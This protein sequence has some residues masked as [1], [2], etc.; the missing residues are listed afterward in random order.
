[1][2]VE[3][4]FGPPGTGKTH[5]LLDIM[6]RELKAGV[7]PTEIAYLTFTRH[8][9]Q[10]AIDRVKQDLDVGPEDLPFFRTLHAIAYRQLGVT[11]G[12]MVA[13][14][15]A[16]RP[17]A[18]RLGL[19]FTPDTVRAD[20]DLGTFTAGTTLGDRLVAFDHW[21]RHRLLGIKQSLMF[22]R[23]DDEPLVV[24]RF[25][26]SYEAWREA[27]SLFDFTDLLQRVTEPLPVKVAIVD[28]AQDLSDLQW[29]AF[30]VFAAQAERV[31]I[32]GDDDQAIFTWAGASPQTFLNLPCDHQRV[33]AQSYRVPMLVASVAHRIIERVKVRQPK[34]W[35][36]REEMGSL[37]YGMG[38]LLDV[39]LPT[40]GS[41]QVLYRNHYVGRD[42]EE[43]LKMAGVAYARNDKAA[44]GAQWGRA[45]VAWERLRKGIP[46]TAAEATAVLEAMSTKRRARGK[47]DLPPEVSLA[48][49]RDEQGIVQTHVQGPWFEALDRIQDDEAQ[50][51]RAVLRH[52]GP[53]G[54]L[55]EPR[56][57]LSTIHA[58][59]GSE[60]DHVYVLGDMSKRTYEAALTDPDTER[61]VLYVGVTRARRTLTL[62]N[63][64]ANPILQTLV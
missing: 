62:L 35:K 57:R 61:R 6:S 29:Q 27:E 4:I 11:Q 64:W 53:S 54:L 40:E 58:A 22:Y 9:R 34:E 21:R 14:N 44:P 13:S 55:R 31:Y 48:W 7:R 16:L 10:V 3:K 28:E 26:R 38:G 5:T 41:I 23:G 8:A 59:K 45:I 30:F 33:L 24:D 49:L 56:V 19:D 25:M 42:P 60:A 36:P 43:A 18:D 51:I 15:R 32:A 20:D 52:H 12:A 17:I 50:Y 37:R 46:V 63:P 2:H 47:P 39:E 1:M